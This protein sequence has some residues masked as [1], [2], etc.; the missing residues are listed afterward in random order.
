VYCNTFYI[1]IIHPCGKVTNTVISSTDIENALKM[2]K[3]SEIDKSFYGDKRELKFEKD[4]MVIVGQE[5]VKKVHELIVLITCN[6]RFG[7]ANPTVLSK[8]EKVKSLNYDQK[9]ISFTWDNIFEKL[10]EL[11][12]YPISQ[13]HAFSKLYYKF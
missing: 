8:S 13:D 11:G 1:T 2:M 12:L 5:D 9:P 6:R 3:I 10:M 4:V 7:Y